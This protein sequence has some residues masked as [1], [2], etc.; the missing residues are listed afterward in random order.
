MIPWRRL[1]TDVT[2]VL[3][4]Y[5]NPP[6]VCCSGGMDSMVLLD[7]VSR[8]DIPFHVFH[9]VHGIRGETESLR[10]VEVIGEKV[11]KIS[12]TR[13]FPIK[14]HIRF[15]QNLRGISNQEATARNQRW[16]AIEELIEELGGG[17]TPIMTAHHL[18]D[19]IEG[20]FMNL[21][22][23]RP[24]D[25]LS[26]RKIN[27]SSFPIVKYKPFLDI[28]KEDIKAWVNYSGIEYH[29]DSTNSDNSNERNWIR[30]VIIPQLMERRN[31]VKSMERELLKASNR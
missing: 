30:N 9:F 8:L 12:T 7:F 24:Q 1:N 28:P 20:I 11:D 27:D 25:T 13:E 21:M 4:H 18:N 26:M 2:K 5:K 14:F 3:D 15:G 16:A 23:G 10:D 31:L 19:D 6:I 22:R 29:E 17:L